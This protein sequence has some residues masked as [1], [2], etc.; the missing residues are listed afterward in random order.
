MSVTMEK[1]QG[2]DW[3]KLYK[4]KFSEMREPLI[5]IKVYLKLIL[6]QLQTVVAIRMVKFC[7]NVQYATS[8][9]KKT[10]STCSK[11]FLF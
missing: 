11:K 10:A 5:A 9:F 7:W 3:V 4:T 6:H 8:D 1:D 2:M